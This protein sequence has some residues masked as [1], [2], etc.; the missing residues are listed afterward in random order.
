MVDELRDRINK[1]VN[2]LN[3]NVVAKWL[4][5]SGLIGIIS[6]LASVIFVW[7]LEKASHLFLNLI[8]GVYQAAPGGEYQYAGVSNPVWWLIILVPA[9]GGLIAGLIIYKW[10]PE[11]E[12]DGTDAYIDA[13]H[14]KRGQISSRTPIIKAFSSILTIGTGGSAG[15]EGPISQIGAGIGSLIGRYLRLSDRDRRLLLIS[16]VAGGVGSIFRCP[17]GG[18]FF[19]T[20]VLFGE[21]E[22]EYEGIIPSIISS[23]VAYSVFASFYGFGPLFTGIPQEFFKH[24]VHLPLYAV[25]G[26]ACALSGILFIYIY[27]FIRNNSSNLL[28]G[29]YAF[30]KPA[31]GGLLLGCLGM[32]APE[33]LGMGYGNIQTAILLKLSIW[34]MA[35]LAFGKMLATGFTL[36]TG[37]S[38]GVFA[39]ALFIG[40]MLGGAFGKGMQSIFGNSVEPAGFVMVG[41]AAFLAGIGNVPIA[42][43]IMTSEMTGGYGLLVPLMAACIIAYA[44]VGK[45]TIY[46]KQ[47]VN[48]AES[49]AHQ[50]DF[51]VDVLEGL[52]VKDAWSTRISSIKIQEDTPLKELLKITQSTETA[53]FPVINH[54]NKLTGVFS[55]DDI[56][57]LLHDTQMIDLLIA[58]DL[59]SGKIIY[60]TPEEKLSSVLTKFTLKDIDELPVVSNEDP[61]NFLG[62]FARKDLIQ[63]YSLALHQRSTGNTE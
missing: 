60:I 18:A 29:R 8:C 48:R 52:T 62:F 16:G 4:F 3:L 37:G 30:I 24:P 54:E 26:L 15:R 17:L 19:A 6:G 11:A 21:P 55:V 10:S 32:F 14:R 27:D 57:K 56:R 1:L 43:I 49:P 47:V 51:V 46:A 53:Y 58:S 33:L 36:G 59:A 13:Y 9:I 34:T 20:E 12:G 35:V 45:R 42:A 22:I 50:G 41:M 2:A 40:A 39:P 38:G 61:Q 44:V 7:L 28:S 63:A 23:I 31:I 5:F 25:L